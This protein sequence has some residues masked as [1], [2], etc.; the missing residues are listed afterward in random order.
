MT[1]NKFI[2]IVNTVAT[3]CFFEGVN[4]Q[5][6]FRP[7]YKKLVLK[8]ALAK[9]YGDIKISL[10]EFWDFSHSKEMSKIMK[11][12]PADLMSELE[13]AIDEQIKYD[14]FM[15]KQTVFDEFVDSIKELADKVGEVN[16]GEMRGLLN[17]YRDT[18][19]KIISKKN[20]AGKNST[21]GVHSKQNR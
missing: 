17:E 6:V 11:Q 15:S 10:E 4:G 8:W 21:H 14:I 9:E 19:S 20:K 2:E 12:I 16:I 7:Y 3:A 13:T 5:K 18:A 1:L